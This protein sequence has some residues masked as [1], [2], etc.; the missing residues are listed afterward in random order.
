MT[1]TVVEELDRLYLLIDCGSADGYRQLSRHLD[2]SGIK[3][4]YSV[5]RPH[6]L[7]VLLPGSVICLRAIKSAIKLGNIL[8]RY[9][10]ALPL[11]QPTGA[12]RRLRPRTDNW[13]TE[14]EGEV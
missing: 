6:T 10:Q 3:S 8:S 11:D 4:T 9:Q 12:M 7:E 2:K 5:R 13:T 1:L 14:V